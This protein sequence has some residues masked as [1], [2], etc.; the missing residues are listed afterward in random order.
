MTFPEDH[1]RTG[2]SAL[3]IAVLLLI[4]AA[5]IA[6]AVYAWRPWSDDYVAPGQ[7]GDDGPRPATQQPGGGGGGP[8]Y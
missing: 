7:G 5:I 8:G 1:A 2:V 3:T 6:V 4:A